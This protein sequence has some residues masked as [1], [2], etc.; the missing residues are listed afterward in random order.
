MGSKQHK[1]FWGS[2]YDRG[3]QYLL[4]MWGD[5]LKKYPDAELHIAYGWDLF[6]KTHSNNPERMQ[7]KTD[8][9]KLMQQPGIKH[10]GRVGKEE[11]AKIRQGCGIWAYPTDF[12]EIFCITAVECQNDGLVPV[13]MNLAALKETVKAG[14]LVDGDIRKPEIMENYLQALLNMM[15]DKEKWE[16]ESHKAH[17][18]AI[19]YQWNTIAYKWENVFRDDPYLPTVSVITVTIREGFFNL[20]ADALSKQTYPLQ[21]IEWIIV[22]DHPEDRSRQIKELEKKYNLSITYCRGS[23]ARSKRRYGIVQA[24]NIGWKK[25]S[26]EL[27]VYLQDFI[28]PPTNGIESMVDIYR[29]HPKAMIAPVDVYYN[30]KTPNMNN[31]FDWWNGE[32]DVLTNLAWRNSRVKYLGIKQSD[33]AYDFEMNYCA[34][35][36]ECVKKLNGWWEFFDDGFGYDNTAIAYRHL[37]NGGELI[38]DDTNICKCINLWSHI[39][40]T[41]QNVSE[42][43][44]HQNVPMFELFKRLMK[45][46]KL[47]LVRDPKLD[48]KLSFDYSV[49]PEIDDDHAIAWVEDNYK[50]IV[51]GWIRK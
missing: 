48:S 47:P 46:N 49:P 22:D 44:R 36:R 26:G 21:K 43:S 2:S 7:W 33:N 14:V 9:D 25:A 5:I 38:V 20:V 39:G 35:P 24:N 37:E 16:K 29:H 8:I 12:Q 28:L 30:C 45:D 18:K 31:K 42:R 50:R 6:L 27:L 3:L 10:Y 34:V 23:K 40:G 32:T 17:K 1:L 51:D 19:Q 41:D 15:G 4:F 13:T 11:L